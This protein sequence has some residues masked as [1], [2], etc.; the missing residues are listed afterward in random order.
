MV[1]FKFVYAVSRQCKRCALGENEER[2]GW[3]LLRTALRPEPFAAP[4]LHFGF[5][6]LQLR[7]IE[8]IRAERINPA[9]AARYYARRGHGNARHLSMAYPTLLGEDKEDEPVAQ[10]K[11]A[12]Q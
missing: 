2:F 11:G 3:S 5:R 6:D 12:C 8:L 4:W 9:N 10:G 1:P 7:N